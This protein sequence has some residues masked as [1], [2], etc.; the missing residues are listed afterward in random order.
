M[1]HTVRSGHHECQT[2]VHPSSNCVRSL[3]SVHQS[4]EISPHCLLVNIRDP[5][6]GLI[7][8]ALLKHHVVT[9]PRS[10]QRV[11]MRH[12]QNVGQCDV[13][14]NDPGPGEIVDPERLDC[15]IVPRLIFLPQPCSDCSAGG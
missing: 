9:H 14:P 8:S 6:N 1:R 3:V 7:S 2:T 12:S 13:I 10:R 5:G 4:Q 11:L 15:M